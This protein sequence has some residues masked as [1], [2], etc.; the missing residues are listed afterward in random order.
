MDGWLSRLRLAGREAW[1]GAAP[2]GWLPFLLGGAL[3]LV[4]GYVGAVVVPGP[5][6]ALAG[7]VIALVAGPIAGFLVRL[8]G[9]A[10]PDA[11][12]RAEAID[13]ARRAGITQAV[14]DHDGTEGPSIFATP[15][16]YRPGSLICVVD[17]LK[18]ECPEIDPL[19]GTF[20]V[21]S[22]SN[23]GCA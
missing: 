16:A 14:L 19:A 1:R 2:S 8:V 9:L 15:F 23:V 3:A 18:Q 12:K 21:R 11:L 5:T 7:G 20:G 4:G 17:G 6:G 22:P 10:D 13:A